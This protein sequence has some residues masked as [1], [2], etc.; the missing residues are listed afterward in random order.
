MNQL[1]IGC[2]HRWSLADEALVIFHADD[3]VVSA[4]IPLPVGRWATELDSCDTCWGGT[5]S[6]IPRS[7]ESSGDVWLELLPYSFLL[8]LKNRI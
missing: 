7:F 6:S 5:G 8:L 4:G 2:I 3:K 1:R